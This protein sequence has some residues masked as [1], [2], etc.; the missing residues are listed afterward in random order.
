MFNHNMYLAVEHRKSANPFV[1]HVLC[2][3]WN[4]YHYVKKSGLANNFK[5]MDV[6]K[7]GTVSNK[8]THIKS[9]VEMASKITNDDTK[10]IQNEKDVQM[11]VP[12]TYRLLHS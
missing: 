8:D 4:P 1:G 3:E 9:T 6:K 11:E 12:N 10:T 5:D 2:N 7:V